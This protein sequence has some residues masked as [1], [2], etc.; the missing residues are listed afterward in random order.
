MTPLSRP[1]KARPRGRPTLE[2]KPAF[3]AVRLSERQ[4]DYLQRQAQRTGVSLGEVLRG[5]INEKLGRPLRDP[6]W[7]EFAARAFGLKPRRH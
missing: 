6:A 5:L 1:P 2:P 4:R 3:V 7:T